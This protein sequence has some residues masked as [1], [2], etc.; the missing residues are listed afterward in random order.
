M[1]KAGPR[2]VMVVGAGGHA[3]VV[4]GTLHACG[5][6]V[7]TVLDDDPSKLGASLL[8]IGVSGPTDRLAEG[9]GLPAVL[10]VGNNRRRSSLAG[11]FTGVE[12]VTAVHPSAVVHPSVQ[13]GAGTVV[14]AGAVVQPDTH[15]G[16]HAIINTAASVDH[17]CTLGD[18]VHVA[19]GT[20]LAGDVRV[21]DGTL[22]GI[23]CAV[24]PGVRIGCWATIGAGSAVVRNVGDGLT[25]A[26]VPAAA[27]TRK[28]R[29]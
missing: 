2:A 18:F 15:I 14:F 24:M 19:P 1:T 20:H 5:F 17:D 13:L 11:R 26:G 3:K 10:A 25:V 6:R 27:L 4:I 21:G 29:L 22:L 8:G 28:E 9:L 7:E 16:R 23:G 12:W